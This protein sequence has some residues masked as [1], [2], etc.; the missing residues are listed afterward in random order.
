[1][2]YYLTID[3]GGTDIKYGVIT[4]NDELV[5]KAITATRGF[6]G[7][8]EIINQIKGIFNELS[9]EYKLE[10]IAISSTGGIDETSQMLTPSIC[11]KDY[12]KVN[13][14]RDLADLNVPVSAENDVNSMALGERDLVP[15]HENMKCLLAMTIGTG[16]GGAIFINDELHR[17]FL[18]TAGE[19]GKMRLYDR[20]FEEL[21]ST[22]ALVS[23]A[24]MVN[25]RIKNGIDVFKLY[26]QGDEKIIPIVNVFYDHLTTGLANLIYILNPEH[27]VIGGGITNRGDQFLQEV[28]THLE[29]KLWD[30]I[31]K[32]F[33]IS[34]AK[35][36][37]DAGMIGAFKLF[38]SKY[39]K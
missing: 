28:M 38:K 33:S 5:F 24:S 25:P 7:G 22:A 39:L 6:L 12:E 37:N 31:N 13:F 8:E 3:I 20:T 29:P 15:N 14:S 23:A 2:R 4:E 1:M 34:I 17:G 18:F 30:Y 19:W 9:K 26:D 10:G 21:A 16:I 27:I 36:K 11:V 35:N 32:K